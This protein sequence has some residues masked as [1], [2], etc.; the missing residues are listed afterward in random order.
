MWLK[1][2]NVRC[3]IAEWKGEKRMAFVLPLK[4]SLGYPM[5]VTQQRKWLLFC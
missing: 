2:K 4:W 3:E 1:G 5:C